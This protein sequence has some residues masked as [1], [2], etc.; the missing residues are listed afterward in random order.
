MVDNILTFANLSMTN[1]IY[2]YPNIMVG[3]TSFFITLK[4][5]GNICCKLLWKK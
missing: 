5:S 2:K 3:F 1:I 4:R